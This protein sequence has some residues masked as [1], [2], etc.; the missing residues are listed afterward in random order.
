M[1]RPLFAAA[2]PVLLSA[3]PL[4]VSA[5]PDAAS[6]AGVYKHLQQPSTQ[7]GV[8]SRDEDILEIVPYGKAK[9]KAYFRLYIRFAN[10]HACDVTGIATT[11]RTGLEYDA[12][13]RGLACNMKIAFTPKGLKIEDRDDLCRSTFC[14]ARGVLNW[15]SPIMRSDRRSIRYGKRILASHEY[16]DAVEIEEKRSAPPVPAPASGTAP[17]AAPGP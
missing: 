16:A 9:D 1:T 12:T 6:L 3:F 14:G 15:T 7:D 13:I 4:P 8:T 5:G 2:L 11:T 17:A 10:Y